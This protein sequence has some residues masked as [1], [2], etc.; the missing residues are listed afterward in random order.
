MNGKGARMASPRPE[1]KAKELGRPHLGQEP[2]GGF[3]PNRGADRVHRAGSDADGCEMTD[4]PNLSHLGWQLACAGYVGPGSG[5]PLPS[6]F[7]GG[8]KSKGKAGKGFDLCRVL[9]EG[10]VTMDSKNNLWG[11][12]Q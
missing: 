12:Y 11:S 3:A 8:P 2:R 10:T 4:P 7:T 6:S 5:L 9:Q 1:L